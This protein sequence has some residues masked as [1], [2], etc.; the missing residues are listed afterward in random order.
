LKA[1]LAVPFE[2]ALQ[3]S[4]KINVFAHVRFSIRTLKSEMR[5]AANGQERTPKNK[6]VICYQVG[7]GGD[8]VTE[9]SI[10]IGYKI[11]W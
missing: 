2:F 10:E 4:S 1:Y 9:N 7:L 6:V 3:T 11:I 5:E 8:K